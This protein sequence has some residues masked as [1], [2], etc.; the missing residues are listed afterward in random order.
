MKLLS[1]Y[2]LVA[3]TMMAFCSALTVEETGNLRAL[4]KGN[5]QNNAN[6]KGKNNNMNRGNNKGK[7]NVGNN[8]HNGRKNGGENKK[9]DANNLEG[10]PLANVINSTPYYVDGHVAY[11][12]CRSDN[13]GI[14]AGGQW[15]AGSRGLCLITHVY[16]NMHTS[17]GSIKCDPYGS[18]GTSYSQFVVIKTGEKSCEVSRRVS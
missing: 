1:I 12:S 10:Y 9:E 16:A 5:G 2:I 14:D 7:K 3:V 11:R 18:S 13:Y 4:R 15:E 17:D 6:K 8:N